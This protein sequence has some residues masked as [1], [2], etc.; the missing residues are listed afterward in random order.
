LA[1]HLEDSASFR[2][3]ARLPLSWT[4]KKSALHRTISAIRA[5]SWEATFTFYCLPRQ[6]HKHLKSTNMFERLNEEMRRRTYVVRI[7][8]QSKRLPPPY[9]RASRPD[10]R[11][12]AR[13]L[14]IPQHERSQ[15]AQENPT[16]PSRL[17][18]AF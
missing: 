12:L 8:P 17:T 10:S 16:A 1:F 15:G 5:E 14:S 3:F 11:E 18:P 9:P 4:P 7:F 6:H 2:A 13:R